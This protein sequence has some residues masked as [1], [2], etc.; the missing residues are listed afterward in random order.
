M[1]KGLSQEEMYNSDY[2]SYSKVEQ[3]ID[4]DELFRWSRESWYINLYFITAYLIM[5]YIGQK[6]MHRRTA[7]DLKPYLFCWNM[8]LC[9]FNTFMAFRL[10]PELFYVLYHF[11]FIYS[12]CR[13][14]INDK[15]TLLWNILFVWSKIIELF[16]TAFLILRKKNVIFMHWFHHAIVLF[17][18]SYNLSEPI[19]ITRW[20]S[21][22]NAT[23]HS[24]M[25]AY[26]AIK[27]TKIKVPKYV[28]MFITTLQILQMI[29]G[30]FVTICSLI[31]LKL[32]KCEV[33]ENR[34]YVSL[35]V[36]S[37][38]L[39]L[40]IKFFYETYLKSSISEKKIK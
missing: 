37:L 34:V 18:C 36:Y 15:I 7:F 38:Y 26:Y 1:M 12:I 17:F 9:L 29:L 39:Y 23:V 21:S 20:F 8:I 3:N 6:L 24:L 27:T 16:D 28:S 19:A 31:Y 4:I 13:L 30:T 40:F 32:Y 11:G 25:Y 33:E 2:S 14:Y 22:M 10:L 5:V 35:S